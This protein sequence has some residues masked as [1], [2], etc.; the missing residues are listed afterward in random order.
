[1]TK[2]PRENTDNT[3]LGY[4]YEA[5]ITCMHFQWKLMWPNW[6]SIEHCL[7]KLR[8]YKPCATAEPFIVL[9]RSACTH[10]L[11]D[12]NVNAAIISCNVPLLEVT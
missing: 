11:K 12:M 7:V 2:M 10:G 1:M 4:R 8:I 6:K 5:T 9:S 3:K